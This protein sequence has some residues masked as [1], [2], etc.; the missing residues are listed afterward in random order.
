MLLEPDGIVVIDV[1]PSGL[2]IDRNL[3]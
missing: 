3:G 2:G 1:G